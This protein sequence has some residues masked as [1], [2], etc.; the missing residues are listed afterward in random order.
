M[1]IINCEK[2]IYAPLKK[3]IYIKLLTFKFFSS[4][5][6]KKNVIQIFSFK[7]QLNSYLFRFYI[8]KQTQPKTNGRLA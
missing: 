6:E 7:L 5:V 1:K 2:Q 4:D 3:D 8:K